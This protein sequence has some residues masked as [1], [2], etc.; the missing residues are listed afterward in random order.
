M[1]K[2]G[3][4]KREIKDGMQALVALGLEGQPAA[5]ILPRTADIWL[6]AIERSSCGCN[7][8]AIDAPRIREGFAR[9]FPD[10]RRW[11]VPAQLVEKIPARPVR[12]SLPDPP[13]TDEEREAGRLA[14]K[15]LRE[16]LEGRFDLPSSPRIN[17]DE[18]RWQLQAQARELHDKEGGKE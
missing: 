1:S 8:E 15:A 18:R 4:L 2:Q 12:Q 9:L 11:P 16:Q 10:L 17:E 7:I 14:L 5:E 6:L 13:P 3:W